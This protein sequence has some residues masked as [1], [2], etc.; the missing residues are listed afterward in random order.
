ML[1]LYNREIVEDQDIE[2]VQ[3][4]IQT[5]S[6]R[7]VRMRHKVKLFFI[8]WKKFI[9]IPLGAL[10]LAGI[11]GGITLHSSGVS[12][13]VMVRPAVTITPTSSFHAPTPTSTPIPTAT[14]TPVPQATYVPV[15]TPTPTAI[16]TPTPEPVD[17]AKGAIRIT[18]LD[19]D[20]KQPL[21]TNANTTI[22][23]GD[24]TTAKS[25]PDVYFYN[26]S[27]D[28]TYEVYVDN[29]SG[30]TY[31]ASICGSDCQSFGEAQQCVR[32]LPAK[33]PS[34]NQEIQ[35]LYSKN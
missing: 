29:P 24:F 9:F 3:Q 22:K 4:S 2:K 17:P 28:Q 33:I 23:N 18:L 31:R 6:K 27:V 10:V 34:H 25:G 35:C 12:K 26:L 14:P 11:I 13:E 8:T 21:D 20:S 32:R 16:P 1:L 7:D 15:A 5:L 19:Y 30:Y